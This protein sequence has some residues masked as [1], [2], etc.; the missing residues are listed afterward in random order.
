MDEKIPT[1][2][3]ITFTLP[4]VRE[5]ETKERSERAVL[6]WVEGRFGSMTR[7]DKGYL[8]YK[9]SA[10]LGGTGAIC[11]WTP[12]K[13]ENRFLVVLSSKA[14]FGMGDPYRLVDEI[15][16]KGGRF[17]RIDIAH[18]DRGFSPSSPLL[19]MD[20]IHRK[21]LKG[22][23][24]TNFRK[25]SRVI[26]GPIHKD[27]A[28]GDTIYIGNRE[29]GVFIRIYNK[30]GEMAANHPDV[31]SGWD[32]WIRLE[33]EFKGDRAQKLAMNLRREDVAQYLMGVLDFREPGESANIARDW[34]RSE[35]WTEFLGAF[36][37]KRLRCPREAG[38]LEQVREWLERQTSGALFLMRETYGEEMIE[39]LLKEGEDKF[40]KNSH[41]K[42][43]K[44]IYEKGELDATGT[45][46]G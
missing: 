9:V 30:N 23:V 24:V 35:W 10:W 16:S 21:L 8:S 22:E 19:D 20:R 3:W 34:K 6:E 36:E 45:E 39:N 42:K 15:L 27:G 31:E 13:P 17:T 1:V 28:I 26:S 29:S 33:V 46:N 32:Y 18:D 11:A 7:R 38:G 12:R 2:D 40:E 4:M 43:L 44:R 41:Y 5:G 25:Q 37:R 14:L